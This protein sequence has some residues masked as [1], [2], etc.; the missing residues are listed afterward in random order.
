MYTGVFRRETVSMA[1][2]TSD[3]TAVALEYPIDGPFKGGGLAASSRY[4]RI[5]RLPRTPNKACLR[6]P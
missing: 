6:S 2:L 1:T 5:R 4:R 3:E